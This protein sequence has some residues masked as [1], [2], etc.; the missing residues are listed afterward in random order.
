KNS[1]LSSKLASS[2]SVS[3]CL[4]LN[5]VLLAVPSHPKCYQRFTIVSVAIDPALPSS[6]NLGQIIPRA[7]APLLKH[8][9]SPALC[10]CLA[11]AYSRDHTAAIIYTHVPAAD[12][13][14]ELC[15]AACFIP[16]DAQDCI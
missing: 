15:T 11:L 12:P 1:N 10:V 5:S 16:S 2:D 8:G 3:T 4:H 13:A 9:W 7:L 14:A 6:S